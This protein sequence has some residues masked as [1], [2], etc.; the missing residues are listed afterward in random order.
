MPNIV[1][2]DWTKP[3]HFLSLSMHPIS[4]VNDIIMFNITT[5]Q[6]VRNS[7]NIP[8]SCAQTMLNK[9]QLHLYP[10]SNVFRLICVQQYTTL[11]SLALNILELK[12][13]KTTGNNFPVFPK[14]DNSNSVYRKGGRGSHFRFHPEETILKMQQRHHDFKH[15]KES[16]FLPFYWILIVLGVNMKLTA[17][18]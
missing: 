5:Y 1:L 16:V 9:Q 3:R 13:K 11:G 15:T 17:G 12:A 14:N 7:L 8:Q 4:V 6:R 10:I 18:T 2:G